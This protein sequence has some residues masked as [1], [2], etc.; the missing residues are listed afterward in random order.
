MASDRRVAKARA[1][2]AK[3]QKKYGDLHAIAGRANYTENFW[4]SGSLTLDY[5]MGTMGYPDNAFVEVYGTPSVG[6]SS[7]F[8]YA[9]VLRSVQEAGGITAVI[10]MEPKVNE[11]W[12]ERLGVNPDFNVIFRP[13]T[14]E[15]AWNMAF[16]LVK[17]AEVD[18]FVFDSIGAVSSD[19]EQE[20]DKVQA[21]GN[22]AMNSWG[23]RRLPPY[24]WKT[25]VGGMFINQVRD[26]TKSRVAGLKESP[27]GWPLKHAFEIRLEAKPGADKFFKKV[28]GADGK[29]EEILIG[30]EIRALIKKDK[31]G[32]EQGKRATFN[33]YRSEAPDG[34]FGIDRA[35]D[36]LV[37][38]LV[39]G[40]IKGA[41]W[42]TWDG[43]PEGKVQGKEKAREILKDEKLQA[44]MRKEI[45]K[46]LSSKTQSQLAEESIAAIAVDDVNEIIDVED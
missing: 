26:D 46:V 45:T 22:S 37:A 13:D 5:I 8:A 7:A 36:A 42:L 4:S 1:L 9:G 33:F 14:G 17:D 6:K 12:L 34:T 3:N 31:A 38:G 2:A 27:G 23:V 30:Q 28:R 24:A 32:E 19:K 25:H 35:Q 21:Y 16:D 39:A 15:Q 29:T 18:Y 41:G 43:F 20:S 40:V 10:A 11:E 44:R